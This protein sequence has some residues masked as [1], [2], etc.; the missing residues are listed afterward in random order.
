MDALN[1]SLGAEK[2]A[3]FAE[4]RKQYSNMLA[5]EKLAKNGVEGEISA[6]RLGNLRNINNPQLQELADIAAQFVK[7]REGQHGAAQRAAAGGIALGL[8][9][10]AGLAAGIATGRTANAALNSNKLREILMNPQAN[11][12]LLEDSELLRLLT[13]A[14]PVAAAQ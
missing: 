11:H 5:L 7:A 13:R 14:A 1:R 2:A 4:T 9:G 8:T 6:A 10:P 12:R 3:G